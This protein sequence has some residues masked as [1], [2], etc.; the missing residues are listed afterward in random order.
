MKSALQMESIIINFIKEALYRFP[1]IYLA[2]PVPP[3][4]PGIYVYIYINVYIHTL[5]FKS[6]GSSRQFRVFHENSL[7]YQ[8]N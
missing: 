2:S 1:A 8:M 5:P 4:V 6:L 7:I 3:L